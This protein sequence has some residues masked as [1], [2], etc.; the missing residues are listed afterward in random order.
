MSVKVPGAVRP[1]IGFPVLL[2]EHGFAVAPE[3]TVS[4]LQAVELLGPRSKTG[5]PIS[6]RTAP[7]TFT[8]MPPSPV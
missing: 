4:F 3:Q 2:R 6:G 1:L 8:L 5:K 7:G